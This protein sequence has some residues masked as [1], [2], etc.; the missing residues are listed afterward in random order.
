MKFNYIASSLPLGKLKIIL[1]L[2]E[3]PSPLR[4]YTFI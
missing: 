2:E 4:C 1:A 3:S